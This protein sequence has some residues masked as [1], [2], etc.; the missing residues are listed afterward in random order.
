MPLSLLL[1]YCDNAQEFGRAKQK[2]FCTLRSLSFNQKTV[3][4][5]LL[6]SKKSVYKNKIN[7]SNTVFERLRSNAICFKLR[8]VFAGEEH[9]NSTQKSVQD[10]TLNSLDV[11]GK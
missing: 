2:E 8:H 4:T 6:F 7:E 1:I 3:E 5:E 9:T 10:S 11:S